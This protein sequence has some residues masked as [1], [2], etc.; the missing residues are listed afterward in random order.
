MKIKCDS[1]AQVTWYFNDSKLP[2]EASVQHKAGSSTYKLTI[3]SAKVAHS[4]LYKCGGRDDKKKRSF[5]AKS[6]V[7]VL[8]KKTKKKQKRSKHRI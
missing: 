7:T 3:S 6:H 4:G 1:D 5:L 2:D 8:P